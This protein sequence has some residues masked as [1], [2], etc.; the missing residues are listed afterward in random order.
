MAV[1]ESKRFVPFNIEELSTLEVEPKIKSE[2][3]AKTAIRQLAD[4]VWLFLTR[5]IQKNVTDSPSI[6]D[7]WEFFAV[8]LALF[9]IQ[10]SVGRVDETK[11]GITRRSFF[12][13]NGDPAKKSSFRIYDRDAVGCLRLPANLRLLLSRTFSENRLFLQVDEPFTVDKFWDK[14]TQELAAE[15]ASVLLMKPLSS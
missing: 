15:H 12:I 2:G 11:N 5:T 1:N 8:Y 3:K 10:L 9:D 14:E 7:V 13:T 4:D 6:D